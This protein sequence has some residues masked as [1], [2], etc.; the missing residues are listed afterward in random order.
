MSTLPD[1]KAEAVVQHWMSMKQ[2]MQHHLDELRENQI[3]HK[4]VTQQELAVNEPW[5]LCVVAQ[6]RALIKMAD[7]NLVLA[8]KE[9]AIVAKF[10]TTQDFQ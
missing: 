3:S 5:Y 10:T 9:K 8:R 1:M 2:Y 7:D 6:T 4:N